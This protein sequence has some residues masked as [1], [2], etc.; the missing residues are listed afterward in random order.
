M[1]PRGRLIRDA[2]FLA[3]L[4]GGGYAVTLYWVA[5]D[6]IGTSEEAKAL[7]RVV[8]L[9]EAEARERILKLG[10][11]VRSEAA[12]AHP[13]APR[14]VVIWQ[15]PAPGTAL[16]PGAEVQIVASAGTPHAAVPDVGGYPLWLAGEVIAA[17]GLRVGDV[18]TLRAPG[19]PGV[20]IA[21]QPGPGRTRPTGST[22]DL[23]VSYPREPAPPPPA[24]PEAYRQPESRD[25]GEDE[26]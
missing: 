22:V 21:T 6:A 1:T 23:V 8:D 2:A 19:E 13:S 24:E 11:R 18:D 3:L 17:A 4:F 5:P 9:P 14:G 20:V 10:L 26:S 12:R 7:P 25:R 16:P 15:D